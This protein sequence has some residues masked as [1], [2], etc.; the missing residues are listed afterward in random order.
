[1]AR[2]T[3]Q[4]ANKGVMTQDGNNDSVEGSAIRAG[5]RHISATAVLNANNA[6][7]SVN[8]FEI[9]GSVFIMAL[10]A[11]VVD[12][13]TFTNC[14]AVHFD[15]WDGSTSVDVTL[16]PGPALSG[17]PVGAFM[18]KD[19]DVG[20]NLKVIDHSSQCQVTEPTAK[21]LGLAFVVTAKSSGT[22]YLRLNYTTTDT[23]INAQIEAHMHYA[24]IN[25][26]SITA[27]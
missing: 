1:M 10:H 17:L 26:G 11:V 16:S 7:A 8:L 21:E 20:S 19:E 22:T 9:T 18:I 27:V 24:I 13:T 25:G 3:S 14:T 4:Q 6:S 5:G 2:L 23:P 15:L 12:A